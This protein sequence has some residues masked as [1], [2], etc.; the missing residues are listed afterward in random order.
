MAAVGRDRVPVVSLLAVSLLVAVVLA[1]A[2][3]LLV[4]RAGVPP[5]ERPERVAVTVPS[6][7]PTVTVPVDAE[8][9][10]L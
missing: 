9:V 7:P 2:M 10:A 1:G 5:A 4:D 8:R 6:P 3:L